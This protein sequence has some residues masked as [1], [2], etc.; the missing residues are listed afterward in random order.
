MRKANSRRLS[1]A[2]EI[3]SGNVVMTGAKDQLDAIRFYRGADYSSGF[4]G[5]RS[6]DLESLARRTHQLHRRRGVGRNRER[7]FGL[8]GAALPT[9]LDGAEGRHIS[10]LHRIEL[11]YQL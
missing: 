11:A 5:G 10:S 2:F 1:L 8:R 3:G 4:V 7:I 9:A 6:V